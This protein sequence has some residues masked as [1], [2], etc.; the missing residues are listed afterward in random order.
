MTGE[1][2]V[3]VP[4]PDLLAA[5]RAVIDTPSASTM[6]A[7]WDARENLSAEDVVDLAARVETL[8]RENR[9]ALRAVAD[10][11]LAIAEAEAANTIARAEIAYARAA[12]A[13]Q[14]TT[15]GTDG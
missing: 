15:E 3:P 8:E 6:R 4:I 2:T 11:R 10:A 14:S 12:L 1:P 9:D 5:A 13:G 7:F